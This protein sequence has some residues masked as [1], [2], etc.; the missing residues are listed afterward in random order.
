MTEWI[1]EKMLVKH[2]NPEMS[3]RGER[4]EEVDIIFIRVKSA[5]SSILD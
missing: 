1:L 5:K 4:L 3:S 2:L